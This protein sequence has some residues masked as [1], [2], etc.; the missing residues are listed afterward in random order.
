[1]STAPPGPPPPGARPGF[2]VVQA[3]RRAMRIQRRSDGLQQAT[4][5][6]A[7]SPVKANTGEA[8]KPARNRQRAPSRRVS[9]A[10][11]GLRRHRPVQ[12]RAGGCGFP[13][14]A[15]ESI[16]PVKNTALSLRSDFRRAVTISQ[17]GGDLATARDA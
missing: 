14:G 15:S 1:M 16:G 7:K 10:R 4:R 8:N 3:S 9:Q 6:Q 12:Q 5:K 11:L 17:G 13:K 2:V